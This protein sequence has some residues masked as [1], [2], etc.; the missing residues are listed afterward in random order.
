[1]DEKDG[2]A[3]RRSV[4]LWVAAAASLLAAATAWS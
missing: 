1:M 4:W 2:G 3:R